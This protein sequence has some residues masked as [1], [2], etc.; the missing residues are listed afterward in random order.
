MT[1]GERIKALRLE[2][3]LSQKALGELCKPKL[4]ASHI[5][6][7]ENGTAPT[8]K[9]LDRIAAALDVPASDLL[10]GDEV[11]HQAATLVDF[12]DDVLK[13]VCSQCGYTYRFQVDDSIEPI[14]T[15]CHIYGDNNGYV[16]EFDDISELYEQ[17]SDSVIS[18]FQSFLF[19]FI[20]RKND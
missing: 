19:K 20:K 16:F 6:R 15:L 8:T 13:Y 14:K 18:D 10:T 9:T 17:F 11:F 5:G 12:G 1:V 7:I 2:R 4:G 3:G